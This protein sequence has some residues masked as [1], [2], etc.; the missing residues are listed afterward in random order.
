M[1]SN[2]D[3]I[4]GQMVDPKLTKTQGLSGGLGG[5]GSQE[6]PYSPGSSSNT[7]ISQKN[8]ITVNG[9]SDPTATAAAVENGQKPINAS[10]IRNVQG[11]VR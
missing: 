4:A 10:L 6:P 9:A 3:S 5:F 8:E 11:A 2:S 1:L 7:T